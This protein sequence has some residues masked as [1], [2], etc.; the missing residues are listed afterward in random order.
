MWW[1][2]LGP[3]LA[4]VFFAV[5]AWRDPRK[6]RTA[7]YFLAALSITLLGVLETVFAV[8]PAKFAI[9]LL[10]GLASLFI[11]AILVLSSALTANGI[12][13]MRKESLH[14]R[15]LL[16]LLLGLGLLSYTLISLYITSTSLYAVLF[17]WLFA[18]VLPI[19]FFSAGFTAYL[20]YSQ[21]CQWFAKHAA[22]PPAAVV[23]LGS[24]LI[25]DK[26]P[27]LLASRLD[28]GRRVLAKARLNGRAAVI[29]V[30]GGRGRDEDRSEA[31][32]MAD[33]LTEQGGE[34]ALIWQEDKSR[35][36]AENLANSRNLLLAAGVSG[37]VAV[38]TN[39]F[40]TFRAALLMR[41]FKL[42]GYAV[43][44]PTAGYFWPSASIREYFAIMRDHWIVN[45]VGFG[46][47]CLPLLFLALRL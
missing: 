37:P 31:A 29:V 1:I 2:W 10:A 14:P 42:P 19:G 24:G 13:M 30:S 27:P 39:N 32:A 26:V 7:V 45:F 47:S 35:T 40:H 21:V 8:V 16:S 15:N 38:V 34:P 11:L 23:V 22:K 20:L 3:L 28:Q 6:M 5:S 41:K 46:L 33:Y 43:G 9:Y 36:T 18:L 44:A 4:W 17:V 12:I 25:E